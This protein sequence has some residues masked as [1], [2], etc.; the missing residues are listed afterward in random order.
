MIGSR[1][2]RGWEQPARARNLSTHRD[3]RGRK[4][5]QRV[6]EKRG[7]A[8]TVIEEF[9]NVFTD[10]LGS[11]D[12]AVHRIQITSDH[13]VKSKPYVIPFHMK[14]ELENDIRDMLKMNIIRASESPCASPVVLFQNQ[15]EQTGFA[16]IIENSIV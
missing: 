16:W 11:T 15:T 14:S 12:L 7:E 9:R 8:R 13:P 5:K 1:R 10:L 3:R 4:N 2:L 6:Y